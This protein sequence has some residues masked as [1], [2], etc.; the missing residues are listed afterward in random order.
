MSLNNQQMQTYVEELSKIIEEGSNDSGIALAEKAI[1]EGVTPVE[2]FTQI[3]QP[4]LSDLGEAF[5]RLDVFLPELMK[6]GMVVKAIQTNVLDQEMLRRNDVSMSNGKVI[7][8]TC[9]GDIHDIGKSMVAMLLQVNGFSVIDLGVSVSPQTFI[10]TAK[11]ENADIIAMSSL[12]TTSLPFIKDVINRL[13]AFDLRNQ[14]KVIVG[15]AAVNPEW[16]SSAGLDG[17]GRDAIEAVDICL[18]LVHREE[19]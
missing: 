18:N 15:G 14:Y 4:I 19:A 7:I 1:A 2:F 3:I 17:Y 8:G 13:K 10:E 6:A 9:Q 5:S 12:L 11:K 16:A